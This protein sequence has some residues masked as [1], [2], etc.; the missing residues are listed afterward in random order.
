M[1]IRCARSSLTWNVLVNEVFLKLSIVTY[2]FK[3]LP[4]YKGRPLVIVDEKM[5][6]ENLYSGLLAQVARAHP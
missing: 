2:G 6:Q 5:A 4:R 3:S 1:G